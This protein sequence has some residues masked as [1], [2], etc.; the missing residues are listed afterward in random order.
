MLL[1]KPTGT[2]GFL[3]LTLLLLSPALADETTQGALVPV[4]EPGYSI[5]WSGGTI[6]TDNYG[7]VPN[8]VDWNGDG[9]KDL[10]VGTFYNGNVYF[11]PNQGTNAAPLFQ[12]REMVE[13]DGV[14]ISLSYG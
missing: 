8:A 11:Y 10:L 1:S 5:A 9:K 12:G 13:A 7:V 2:L 3:I 14:P 6:H 4:F